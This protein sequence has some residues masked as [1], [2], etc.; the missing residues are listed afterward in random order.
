M[1]IGQGFILVTPLQMATF[2]ASLARGQTRTTPYITHDPERR[3]QTTQPI[4]LS[5]ANY[6]ALVQGMEECTISGTART[7]FTTVKTQQIPGLRVAG[8][9]GTAQ[10]RTPEGTVNFAWFICFAP[11]EN[12]QVAIAVMVEGDQPGEETGGGTFSAPVAHDILAVWAKKHP[13]LIPPPPTPP[14]QVVSH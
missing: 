12:P 3:T 6:A 7:A 8:K 9:T 5:P 1:S 2:V 10:K 4:G 13:D 14:A 11:I